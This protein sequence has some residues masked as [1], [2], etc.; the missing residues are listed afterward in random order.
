MY[1]LT[2]IVVGGF[3]SAAILA[4]MGTLIK[5]YLGTTHFAGINAIVAFYFIFGAFFT[6]TIECTA[7]VY[8]SEIWPTHLRSEGSTLAYASFFGNAI[9]YSAPVAVALKN[10][11]WKFYMILLTVTVV[12][13]IYIVFFF[14]EVSAQ[15]KS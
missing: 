15:T 10:I 4:M 2:Y 1:L 11:G 3:G 9:A 7:Y 8:G 13:T 14:P 5:F 12:S 6:S